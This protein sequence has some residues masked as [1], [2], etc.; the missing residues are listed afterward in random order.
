MTESAWQQFQS[1][2]SGIPRP[3][4]DDALFRIAAKMQELT[5]PDERT[6]PPDVPELVLALGHTCTACEEI[7]NSHAFGPENDP[8]KYCTDGCTWAALQHQMTCKG[9]A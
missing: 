4:T 3:Y 7:I 1:F 9:R 6:L 2:V 5:T 8:E